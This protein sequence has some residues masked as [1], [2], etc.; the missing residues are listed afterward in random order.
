MKKEI[1]VRKCVSEIFWNRLAH[2]IWMAIVLSLLSTILANTILSSLSFDS[3]INFYKFLN[4]DLV[5]LILSLA[6]S[7]AISFFGLKLTNRYV[8]KK[9]N[10][11]KEMLKKV[12][13]ILLIIGIILS[14]VSLVY[15]IATIANVKAE[16]E[17]AFE[18]YKKL[19][20]ELGEIESVLESSYLSDKY[21]YEAIGGILSLILEV[22]MVKYLVF[23][24]ERR[25]SLS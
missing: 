3:A 16:A 17:E 9:Y 8:A 21:V 15:N 23:D 12:E 19:G 1:T 14:I 2:A 5:S 4:N 25:I 24:L 10:V 13:K 18:T 20:I 7:A 11:D 6:T 22:V